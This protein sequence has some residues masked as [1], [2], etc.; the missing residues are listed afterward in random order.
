[1]GKSRTIDALTE[2]A[3]AAF[4]QAMVKVIE[5]AKQTGTPIIIWENGQVKEVSPH[6]IT[7]N[8][9]PRLG[10]QDCNHE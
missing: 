3:D 5:K 7:E 8:R 1:M 9:P 4:P 10:E 2:K 6:E